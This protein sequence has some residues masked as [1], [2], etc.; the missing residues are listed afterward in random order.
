MS[1][2][3]SSDDP[4]RTH[5]AKILAYRALFSQLKSGLK[6]DIRSLNNHLFYVNLIN[7]ET[8]QKSDVDATLNEVEERLLTHEG[9]FDVFISVLLRMSDGPYLVNELTRC[10]VDLLNQEPADSAERDVREAQVISIT[11]EDVSKSG[12]RYLSI[13]S[14]ITYS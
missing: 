4:S 14:V 6:F 13:D 2:H 9:V 5:S 11:T 12:R 1:G 8:Q 3:G 7:R 10:F